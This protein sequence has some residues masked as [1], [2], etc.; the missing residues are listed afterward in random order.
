VVARN[1]PGGVMVNG[2]S[3]RTWGFVLAH[4]WGL[5][6]FWCYQGHCDQTRTLL[7]AA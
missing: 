1:H 6:G 5:S 7:L 3:G 4:R 2:V